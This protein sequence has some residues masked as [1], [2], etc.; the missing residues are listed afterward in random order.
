MEKLTKIYGIGPAIAKQY[1]HDGIN[2]VKLDLDKPIR[3]QLKKKKIFPHLSMATQAD[4]RWNP[5]RRIQ[6]TVIEKIDKEFKK[7]LP[8]IKFQIAGSYRRKKPYSR[9]IDLIISAPSNK[10]TIE[11]WNNFLARIKKSSLIKFVEVF[12]QGADKVSS[13]LSFTPPG[14]KINI[15]VDVFFTDPSEYM[16][17]LLYATGSGK[18]NVRMRATAKRKGYLLNQHGLFQKI[19][20]TILK[21]IP[22]KTEHDLFKKLGITFLEPSKRIK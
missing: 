1:I 5:S 10:T 14:H 8:G 20:S 21:R 9:D 2:G 3:A 19:S 16:F 4:L 15:K 7:L 18:F 12:A 11:H 13:V 22:V 6:R 17:M